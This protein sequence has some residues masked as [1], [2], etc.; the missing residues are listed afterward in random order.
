MSISKG[1]VVTS[2][3]MDFDEPIRCALRAV[4]GLARG[5]AL[6]RSPGG[7]LRVATVACDD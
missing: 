2:N 5:P 4:E 7:P 3:P 6:H 1:V